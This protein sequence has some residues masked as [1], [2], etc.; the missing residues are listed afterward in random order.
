MS[1]AAIAIVPSPAAHTAPPSGSINTPPSVN[2]LEDLL[3]DIVAVGGDPNLASAT[4]AAVQVFL[5][6]HARERKS[7]EA[8]LAFFETHQLSMQPM[9]SA[10]IELPPLE[11]R[12]RATE[13]P[14]LIAPMREPDPPLALEVVVP[15]RARTSAW[16]WALGFAAISG[17]F[18]AGSALV[19][20][21]RDEFARARADAAANAA[22]LVEVRS[23]SEQLRAQLREQAKQNQH[24]EQTAQRLMQTLLSPLDPD[25]QP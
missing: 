6:E 15:T 24:T 7:H 1:S 9:A 16:F 3:Y 21:V 14:V 5:H 4:L 25:K 22:A 17:A 18:A 20:E 12:G 11:V 10:L 2:D 8:F 23:E 19:L 13:T